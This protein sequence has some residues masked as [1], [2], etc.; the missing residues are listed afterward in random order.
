VLSDIRIEIDDILSRLD[1]PLTIV[2]VVAADDPLASDLM[3]ELALDRIDRT[4]TFELVGL[5][6]LVTRIRRVADSALVTNI[7]AATVGS[8]VH[9]LQGHPMRL[10]YQKDAGI[11]LAVGAAA[12]VEL[13]AWR[14]RH[15]RPLGASRR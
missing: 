2:N 8:L 3:G 6:D 14:S 4:I 9:A 15:A 12:N 10:G 7:D 1:A 11:W 5:D 13:P